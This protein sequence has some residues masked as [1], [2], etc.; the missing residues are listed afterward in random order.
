MAPLRHDSAEKL[1]RRR[2]ELEQQMAELD[3][4]IAAKA[5]M[6]PEQ[7]IAEFLH[8][9]FCGM[10][11]DDQCDWFYGVDNHSHQRYLQK[12]RRLMTDLSACISNSFDVQEENIYRIIQAV[13]DAR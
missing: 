9:R 10:S 4:A 3:A 5:Q 12:A 7:R 6:T 11:H 13:A 2:A 1:A 8:E